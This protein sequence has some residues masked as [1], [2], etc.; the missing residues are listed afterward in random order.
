MRRYSQL[1]SLRGMGQSLR[2]KNRKSLVNQMMKDK[3]MKGMIASKV[4][5]LMCKEL[6]QLCKDN[7]CFTDKSMPAIE[8]F[9]WTD[10]AAKLKKDCPYLFTLLEKSTKKIGLE[11]DIV[12]VVCA[13]VLLKSHSERANILQRLISV[14]LFASHAPKQVC[15]NN[16]ND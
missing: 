13:S 3:T 10:V 6:K 8:S 7:S 4:G 2:R 9:N 5:E 14:L 16:V 15:N 12:I 11:K 1:P